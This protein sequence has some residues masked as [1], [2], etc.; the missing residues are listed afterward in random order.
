MRTLW[1]IAVVIATGF[2]G[3]AVAQDEGL[4]VA[5]QVMGNSDLLHLRVG[6]A[7][8]KSQW[9]LSVLH[10]P[11]CAERD[12]SQAFGAFG[13]LET[14]EINLLEP[15]ALPPFWKGLSVQGFANIDVAY[16]LEYDRVLVLPGVGLMAEPTETMSLMVRA[17][18]PLGD[19][20]IPMSI[21][22]NSLAWEAGLCIR[23]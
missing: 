20:G 1:M 13:L 16:D 7:E 11:Q 2:A 18:Y 6:L 4:D 22:L 17:Y 3:V 14:P 12:D 23:F 9:G 8:G 21:D 19:E 15:G 5:A 10:Q